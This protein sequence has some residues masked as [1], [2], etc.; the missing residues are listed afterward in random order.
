MV[1]STWG[2]AWAKPSAENLIASLVSR[3]TWLNAGVI[4][5]GHKPLNGRSRGKDDR[6][7][8]VGWM[9]GRFEPPYARRQNEEQDE[10]LLAL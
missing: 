7:P 9:I 10:C 8:F 4:A 5:L 6:W 2:R 3:L 1:T